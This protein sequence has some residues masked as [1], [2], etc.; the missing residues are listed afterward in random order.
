M[1]FLRNYPEDRLVTFQG[2]RI[3]PH[4]QQDALST[5][6]MQLA[7]AAASAGR[8]YISGSTIQPQ[9][10]HKEQPDYSNMAAQQL[11]TQVSC[12][13][14]VQKFVIRFPFLFTGNFKQ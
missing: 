2:P 6:N 5:A 4:A 14:E 1:P 12:F 13:S 7:A 3:T 9:Q 10:T 11:N 8:P